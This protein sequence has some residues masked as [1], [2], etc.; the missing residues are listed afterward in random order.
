MGPKVQQ[1]ETR[2]TGFRVSSSEFL[3]S[4]DKSVCLFLKSHQLGKCS[5]L[6]FQSIIGY[7][8]ISNPR[9]DA[10]GF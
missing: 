9:I 6:M 1:K 5:H 4:I 8:S 10:Y 2:N 7:N 3:F